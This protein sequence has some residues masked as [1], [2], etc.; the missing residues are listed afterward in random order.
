M[1]LYPL[2]LVLIIALFPLNSSDRMSVNL[3][4][5]TSVLRFNGNTIQLGEFLLVARQK[6]SDVFMSFEKQ[7][8]D[9]ESFEKEKFWNRSYKGIIPIEKL[10]LET[11]K[12]LKRIKT[13]QAL[14]EKYKIIKKFD[15]SDFIMTLE[16]ENKIRL[17]AFKNKK[18]LYGLVGY[19]EEFYYAYLYS[20]MVIKLKDTLAKEVF[21]F[22]DIKYRNYYEDH[23][24]SLFRNSGKKGS[25]L[26]ETEVCAG[27]KTLDEV[28]GQIRQ[29]LIDEEYDKLIDRYIT[30]MELTETDE[31]ANL[32]INN[33][34]LSDIINK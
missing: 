33:Y 15:Y 19:P 24:E 3:N 22:K 12:Q 28:K 18:T 17:E 13:E 29:R 32:N 21:I 9:A 20:N 31:S 34:I 10:K 7:I 4:L 23:K 11:E 30:K 1:N 26:V 2:I 25:L 16:H 5:E 14:A 27:Y 8:R 6:R